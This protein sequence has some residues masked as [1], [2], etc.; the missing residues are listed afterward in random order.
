MS[1][2]AQVAFF[3]PVLGVWIPQ[4]QHDFG[5]SRTEISLG[6][7][8]G[9]V[10]AAIVTPFFGSLID[11]YGG[12]IFLSVGGVIMA[13]GLVALANMQNEWQFFAIYCVGRGIAAGL[14][15]VAATV[16]VS[17]WFVRRRALA[18]GVTTLGTRLG[19]ATMP[20]G[21]QLIIDYSGWRTAA[22]VLAGL[23]A[24]LGVAPVV[25]W[26]HPRPEEMG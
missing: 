22:Y 3:N 26:L 25:A 20:I 24:I 5:W 8:A 7:T 6:A 16:T 11:R 18:V 10:F 15:T 4:F 21:V 12:K 1:A 17:K 23:V 13:L 14:L 9:T 19:F 2:F